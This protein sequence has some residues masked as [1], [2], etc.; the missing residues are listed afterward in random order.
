MNTH[1]RLTGSPDGSCRHRRGPSRRAVLSGALG[2]GLVV[3]L[4][5]T[6]APAAAAGTGNLV[7]NAGF[8]EVSGSL[9]ARWRPF[10]AASATSA[11]VSEDR[12]RSGRRSLSIDDASSSL[13]VG[14][15]SEEVTAIP[16]WMYEASVF[17][18]VEAGQASLY[19]E[20][21][22]G[23]G[24]RTA[25]EFRVS[26]Q[27]GT[28]QRIDVGAVAPDDAVGVTV[29]LYQAASNTG[30]AYYD[31]VSLL[32]APRLNAEILGPASLTAAVRGAAVQGDSVFL[33]SRYNTP[34]GKLRLAQFDLRTGEALSVDDLDIDSSGGHALAGDGRHLYVG[35]AGSP[36]V[37]RFD[38]ATKALE[39]WALAGSSTTWYY[40]MV[41]AGDSLYIG[42]YPDCMVKR[43]R[44]ADASVSTY[45]RVSS[46]RYA[47]AVA[48][49]GDD[50]YGGS[51]APGS[52]LRWPKDGGEP[53]D[54][55]TFLSDSPVGIL[56]LVVSAG[57]VYVA[58]GRQ[59]ISFERDGSGRV[60]REIPEEDRYVDRLAVGA[61]GAVYALTRLTT[62]LYEVTDAGLR[63]VGRPL[64]DVENQ[65]LAPG[66]SG[67]LTGVSGLGHVWT[68]AADGAV[69]V[70]D[71]ATR[72]FGYPEVVQSMLLSSRQRVWVG[73]HYAM[74]VHHPSRGTSER[75]DINGEPKA[76]AEGTGGEIYAGLYPS[77]QVV[78]VDPATHAITLLATLGH[79]QLRVRAMHVDRDR[80]QLLVASGPAATKHT[81]ALSFIDL[82]TGG[83][84][85]HREY[86]PEQSVMDVAVAGRTAYIVGDT[87]GE[88]TSG[89]LRPVAQVAA[90]DLDTRELLWR[91]ELKDDWASYES[92]HVADSM[93][94]A[95]AR[96]PRGHWYAY[97]LDAGQ[98]VAEGDLGGYGQLAGDG[99]RVF[100]WVHWS[101]DICELTGSDDGTRTLYDD[102]P[103]GWYN[104]PAFNLTPD[105]GATWGMWGTELARFPL[106]GWTR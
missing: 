13:G 36:H 23:G 22:D 26:T 51:S 94:Y 49:D 6:R 52:L 34:E 91:E 50:V 46:S 96:R 25:F 4:L 89:P 2:A 27:L 33:S 21:W 59:V 70:W 19:L 32:A 73:G 45:G 20:F 84:D 61:D 44:L 18:Y 74:T 55:S 53:T 58:S 81:G 48:V 31:D 101:G 72:G 105:G 90:V 97:D 99:R 30:K 68:M 65:L 95:M 10:S 98:V 24:A 63:K 77:T 9:P 8:E 28:W 86:L 3:G 71:T 87:Y 106:P 47:T 35:P 15:R 100:S 82:R 37:W 93:L 69:N 43:I 14:M 41:V 39:R 103:V 102:V 12:V 29:L 67:G 79:E 60:S 66:P 16:G 17:A 80:R 88:A 85:V 7:P 38:P 83:L 92:V 1:D 5:G 57:T 104:D 75:F 40:D 76:L 64:A 62:N 54:L 42:T 11:V 78:S 56:D